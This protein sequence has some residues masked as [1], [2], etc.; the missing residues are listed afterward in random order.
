MRLIVLPLLLP[1]LLLTAGCKDAGSDDDA[2]A[3]ATAPTVAKQPDGP[4]VA[5]QTAKFAPSSTT[6]SS[7]QPEVRI[8][9]DAAGAATPTPKPQ[10]L[11]PLTSILG[12][13]R[14][15]VPGEIIDVDLDDDDGLAEYEVEI[16]TAAGRKIEIRIDARRGT[17]LEE[18]ED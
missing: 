17:V 9:G 15:R 2:A 8:A 13:A 10:D 3:P 12:I 4:T 14:S 18:E 11:L 5:A 7:R 16:L 1:L 6:D